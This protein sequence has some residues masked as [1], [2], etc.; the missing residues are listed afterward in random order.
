[1]KAGRFC[2]I[3]AQSWFCFFLE[4]RY[5]GGSCAAG[6]N[7]GNTYWHGHRSNRLVVPEAKVTL[8]SPERGITRTFT[9]GA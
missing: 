5:S 6:G 3:G 1:M 4:V 7:N 8:S 9:T 2:R